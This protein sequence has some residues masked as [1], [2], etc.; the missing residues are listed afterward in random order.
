M[1]LDLVPHQPTLRPLGH[2]VHTHMLIGRVVLKANKMKNSKA[3]NETRNSYPGRL[4][5]YNS[6][7]P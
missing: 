7:T 6:R 4:D 2:C 5:V 3:L 1:E